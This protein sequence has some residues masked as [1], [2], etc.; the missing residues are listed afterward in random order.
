[1]NYKFYSYGCADGYIT[2]NYGLSTCP[3]T[4]PDKSKKIIQIH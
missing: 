2:D 3:K 1:M 4:D